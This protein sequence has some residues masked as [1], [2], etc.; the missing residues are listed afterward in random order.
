MTDYLVSVACTTTFH[1]ANM[2]RNPSHYPM[3]ARIIGAAAV[4]WLTEHWG[5]GVWYVTM[6]RMRNL[7]RDVSDALYRIRG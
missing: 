6:V 1:R 5:A 4:G 2:R 3:T 7:V